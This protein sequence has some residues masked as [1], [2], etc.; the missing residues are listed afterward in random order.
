MAFLFGQGHE[1]KILVVLSVLLVL[2][3]LARSLVSHRYEEQMRRAQ[4]RQEQRAAAALAALAA[5]AAAAT[6][7]SP[8]AGDDRTGSA[9]ASDVR[10]ERGSH[11]D[12]TMP[13]A[14]DAPASSADNT[15]HD[16]EDVPDE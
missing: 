10:R 1:T 15:A 4:E 12:G 11:G 2:T 9:P 6:A 14:A 3:L 7:E 5:A 16:R 13:P 8:A